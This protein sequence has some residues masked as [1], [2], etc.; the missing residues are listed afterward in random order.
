M[1]CARAAFAVIAIALLGGHVG[2]AR[3]QAPQASFRSRI[4]IVPLD[5]RV[6]DRDGKPV[7]DLKQEDFTIAEEGVLQTIRHFSAH[8]LSGEAPA[9]GVQPELRKAATAEGLAP[10]NRRVF[11]LLL[12]RG[13]MQG[14]SKELPA[15]LEFLQKRLVPRDQVAVLAF[16]RGTD[17]TTNHEAVRA[18]V[19]RYRDRHEK[20]ETLLDEYLSG[21]RAVYGSKGIPGF[22]QA[23][24]DGVFA[25]ATGLRPREITPGQISDARQIG[26]DVRRTTDDLQRAEILRERTGAFAG[27]PDPG[28]T[29]TAERMDVTFDEYVSSQVGLNHDLSN[30]YAGIDYLRY[31]D[32]EKHLVF[33]T[34]RGVSLPRLENNKTLASAASD[35]RVAL[36]IIYI[37]GAL[38]APPPRIVTPGGQIVMAA[39]PSAAA[40]FGQTFAVS[41]MR[42]MSEMTGG[43]M[44]AFRSAD[45]AFT[46]LDQATR[47]QYLLGYSPSN[48]AA[49][50]A[51][52]RIT[53]RVKRP[54]TTVLYRQG[55]YATPQLVPMD[56]RQFITFNRLTAAGAYQGVIQDITVKVNPPTRR[57]EGA[58]RELLVEGTIHSSR[59]KFVQADGLHTASLDIGVYAG[60]DGKER[61]VGEV[62][63][64]VDLKLTDEAYRTFMKQGASFNVRIPLT[65]DPKYVKVI[66]Y[67]YA[68]DLLGTAVTRLR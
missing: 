58:D 42:M 12:G 32:G 59:I 16:N 62:L 39:L 31:L 44:T 37:G 14:P 60:G 26:E 46:R 34:P 27:L 3:Q 1:P 49:N 40:L 5:V 17:F 67:D 9:P 22:I 7:T 57:G 13:R 33:L 21:L 20:I 48:S 29:S 55:Y 47:F 64:K 2:D 50:G 11:L 45:Y 43:Q 38:G 19:E 10:Q 41:D 8:A 15:L 56:R 30:L 36:D 24:I 54:G 68:A 23:E 53:V 28:A 51:Y 35:A 6:L 18:V 61:V 66:V 25:G 4:T 52:R 63:R 65:G